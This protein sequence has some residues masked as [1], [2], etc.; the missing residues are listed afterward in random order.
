MDAPR[1]TK[2]QY[3]LAGDDSAV[4]RRPPSLVNPLLD[5]THMVP[6]NGGRA[7]GTERQFP[8][9]VW[10]KENDERD[11]RKQRGWARRREVLVSIQTDSGYDFQSTM[12]SS[13]RSP[14]LLGPRQRLRILVLLVAPFKSSCIDGISA[15]PGKEIP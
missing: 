14:L 3:L 12:A 15:L 1:L 5:V 7:R 6:L 11:K 8:A 9:A 2:L 10:G 4:L 13:K